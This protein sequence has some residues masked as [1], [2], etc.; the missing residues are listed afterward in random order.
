MKG[1]KGEK[2][3]QPMVHEIAVEKLVEP[4]LPSEA[5][6][7]ES[8]LAR[9]EGQLLDYARRHIPLELKGVL[10]PQDVVQDTFF[11]AF[12]RLKEFVPQGTDSA[13]RWLRTIARHRIL[14]ALK[15]HRR[16]KRGGGKALQIR[17]LTGKD[18]DALVLILAELAV[19]TRTPSESA[20]AHELAAALEDAL[21]KLKPDYQQAI[22]LRYI[23]GEQVETIAMA[24]G[25]T[26]RAVHMVCNRALK[27]LRRE[28]RSKSRYG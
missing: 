4:G 19:Y 20:V 28:L 6:A 25:L 17:D 14:N 7:L 26:P 24:L 10:E 16:V 5:A 27:A 9:Y 22:R 13:W 18:D 21:I 1:V 15:A 23:Q 3:G 12:R 11:E 8:L 2:P